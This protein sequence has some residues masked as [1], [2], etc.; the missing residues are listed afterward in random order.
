MARYWNKLAILAKIETVAGT[1]ATPTGAA[2][3]MVMSDVK[4]TPLEGEEISRDLI[5]PYFG[6]QGIMLAGTYV[7][8]EGSVELAGSGTAGTAPAYGPLLRACGMAET[9]V[10]TTSVTYLPASAAQESMSIY[11]NLDGVNHKMLMA[12]GTFKLDLKPKAIPKI[13]FTFTG[14][15]GTIADTALPTLTRTAWKDPIPVSKANTP[16]YSI[17]GINLVAESLSL[18]LGNTVEPRHLIGAES[19]V[20]TDRKSKGEA[21]VEAATLA[22]KDW[23]AT[24]LAGTKG[25]LSVIHG[26]AAGNI[27]ALSAPAVQIGK[28]SYGQTQNVTNLTLPLRFTSSAGDDEISIVVR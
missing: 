16:T 21:V 13:A 7:T 20:I 4:L 3:A 19:V 26:T 5:L 6:D 11:V 25:A 23:F 15:I 8:L 2:N 14:L 9:I 27:V 17:H 10:A 28:P 24:A 18:D 22:T 1:D 12:R